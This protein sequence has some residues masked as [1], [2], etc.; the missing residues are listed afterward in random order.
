MVKSASIN[1]SSPSIRNT[2]NNPLAST[3]ALHATS[4]Q[5]VQVLTSLNSRSIDLNLVR[6]PKLTVKIKSQLLNILTTEDRKLTQNEATQILAASTPPRKYRKTLAALE[7]SD[8]LAYYLQDPTL[9]TNNE[10]IQILQKAEGFTSLTPLAQLFDL[11]PQLIRSIKLITSN[12]IFHYSP[13]TSLIYQAAAGCRY[14]ND[15]AA[16]PISPENQRYLLTQLQ[17]QIQGGALDAWPALFDLLANPDT[18]NDIKSEIITTINQNYT[19]TNEKFTEQEITTREKI[20]QLN[21]LHLKHALSLPITDTSSTPSWD[22][23]AYPKMF[24]L[25]E[26]IQLLGPNRYPTLTAWLTQNNLTPNPVKK[27]Q[28][29]PRNKTTRPF[30]LTNFEASLNQKLSPSNPLVRPEHENSLLPVSLLTLHEVTKIIEPALDPL[31]L[32]AWQTF[33][34][35]SQTAAG[36][37]QDLL[38]NTLTLIKN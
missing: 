34:A 9:Y 15:R 16:S 18:K 20:Y 33:F 12:R 5:A 28:S 2:Q 7:D 25:K 32:E 1:T 4:P 24:Q 35:L 13:A 17:Y 29:T 19:W 37:L 3:I 21:K 10:V 26:S 36:S 31:G 23:P 8:K 22:D 38:D 11:R 30:P 14:L 6:N 27:R